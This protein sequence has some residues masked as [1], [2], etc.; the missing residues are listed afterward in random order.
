MNDLKRRFLISGF[1]EDLDVGCTKQHIEALLGQPTAAGVVRE[2]GRQAFR[3]ES[4]LMVEFAK[5]GQVTS[6]QAVTTL[7]ESGKIVP[8]P[9]LMIN[10]DWQRGSLCLRSR[11]DWQSHSFWLRLYRSRPGGLVVL[12]IIE[13]VF[14]VEFIFVVI[15]LI[16][17]APMFSFG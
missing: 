8:W 3:Y 16:L 12:V 4:E 6:L 2:N 10:Y 13:F 5:D 17:I 14:V 9:K 11:Y 15:E 7:E 1:Y